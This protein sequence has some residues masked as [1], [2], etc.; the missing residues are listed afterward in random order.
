MCGSSVKHSLVC[1]ETRTKRTKLAMP[2]SHVDNDDRLWCQT[3]PHSACMRKCPRVETLE[4]H[5]AINA[6]VAPA[7]HRSEILLH[8]EPPQ[9]TS[10][11]LRPD[12]HDTR[13]CSASTQTCVSHDTGTDSTTRRASHTHENTATRDPRHHANHP[14]R[15]PRHDPPSPNMRCPQSP[16]RVGGRD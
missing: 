12:T 16:H 9:E 11:C 7:T 15:P 3:T 2:I 5:L 6:G 10:M 8:Q 13:M 14:H 1:F 4:I